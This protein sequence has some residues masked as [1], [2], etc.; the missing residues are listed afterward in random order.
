MSRYATIPDTLKIETDE[1]GIIELEKRHRLSSGRNNLNDIKWYVYEIDKSGHSHLGYDCIILSFSLITLDTLL[2]AQKRI[3]K[4]DISTNE[5]PN[6]D[7]NTGNIHP[8]KITE[9]NNKIK[10]L[11]LC[12]GSG[13][14]AP[15]FIETGEYYC[16]NA[17]HKACYYPLICDEEALHENYRYKFLKKV[18]EELGDNIV[19]M[20]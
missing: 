1:F 3:I 10:Q 8:N 19:E 13:P 7:G 6:I 5:R 9:N 18:W 16:Y 12:N 2:E 20:I 14:L 17:V 11:I 4:K 15:H